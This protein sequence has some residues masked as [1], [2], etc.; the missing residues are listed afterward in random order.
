MPTTWETPL[1]T[2]CK[3]YNHIFVVIDSFTKFTWLYPTKSTTTGKVVNRLELQRQV[4]G[5]P[6]QIITDKGTA[7]TSQEFKDYCETQDIKHLVITTGLPRA[8]GQ[9]ERL[10]Q[11]IISVLSKLSI[12]D[13]T[14]WYK[15]VSQLQRILNSTY[16]RINTTPFELLFGVKMHNETN[17][18]VTNDNRA[19]VS[20]IFR[21]R[22][23]SN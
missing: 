22:A 11:T 13:P 9:V 19:R 17:L 5:N 10:N 4:F 6:A 8:N 1:D 18:K 2:T 14:K 16:H 15:H 3:N 7:F 20:S 12:G 23:Q 21:R